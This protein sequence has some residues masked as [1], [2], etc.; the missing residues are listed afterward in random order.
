MVLDSIET[1]PT[2]ATAMM[3][4]ATSTSSKVKPRCRCLGIAYWLTVS[5]VLRSI[6]GAPV[7]G[8]MRTRR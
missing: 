3:V 1:R 6:L 2:I 7:M 5:P 8:S 4:V